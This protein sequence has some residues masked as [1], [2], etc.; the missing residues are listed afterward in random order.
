MRNSYL[1]VFYGLVLLPLCSIAAEPDIPQREMVRG[2]MLM[3]E[4]D[5]P[6]RQATL[7]DKLVPAEEVTILDVVGAKPEPMKATPLAG[8][9]VLADATRITG[10]SSFFDMNTSHGIFTE[11][12]VVKNPKLH[13]NCDTLEFFLYKDGSAKAEAAP[14]TSAAPL[15]GETPKEKALGD[16]GI[17][18]AI[19]QGRKVVIQNLNAAGD[20]QFGICR[21]ATY[22]GETGDIVL[23][24][25]PQIQLPGRVVTAT[26]PATYMVL[27][28]NG[29]FKVE[30]LHTSV[31]SK[32]E[33]PKEEPQTS[34]GP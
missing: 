23:R 32:V 21:H 14:S 4:Q 20:M 15:P 10:H 3:V 30:G 13:I 16:S 19:A 9:K 7:A 27:K 12:V 18:K 5:A 17:E 22:D 31:F 6:A 1:N 11:D 8:E 26:D 29:E 28:Q 2:K 24:D 33:R 34:T 25:G